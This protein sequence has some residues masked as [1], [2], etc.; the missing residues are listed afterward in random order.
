LW[1][2][3]VVK[4]ID[5]DVAKEAFAEALRRYPSDAEGALTFAWGASG[6]GAVEPTADDIAW[7]QKVVG[8]VTGTAHEGNQCRGMPRAICHACG[9]GYKCL[10]PDCEQTGV[11]PVKWMRPDN[12]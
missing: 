11:H 9:L 5:R 12:D 1:W 7:G 3:L 4:S 6:L 8:H 10:N 2:E